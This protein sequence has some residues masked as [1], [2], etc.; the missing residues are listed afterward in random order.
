MKFS[1]LSL[2]AALTFGLIAPVAGAQTPYGHDL[3]E[4][5]T[6]KISAV[7][8]A[9][10][11]E[12]LIRKLK[13]VFPGMFDFLKES[14]FQMVSGHRYPSDDE[15]TVRYSL[16]FHKNVNGKYTYGDFSF[17]GEELRIES[18]HYQPLNIEDAFFPGKVSKDEAKEI[19]QS[20]LKKID[21]DTNYHFGGSEEYYYGNQTLTEPIQ[22]HF[23]FNREKNG[24][25]LIDQTTHITVYASGDVSSF[26]H[27]QQD[28]KKETFDKIDGLI[29][30]EEALKQVKDHLTLNLR[31]QIDYT[32]DYINPTLRLVYAPNEKV[33]GIHAQTGKWRTP[34]GLVDEYP[35]VSEYKQLVDE[36][37]K[38]RQEG[39]TIEDAKKFAEKFLAIDS[40]DVTLRIDSIDERTMFN[41][42]D[43]YSIHYSYDYYHGGIGTIMEIDKATGD[44]TSYYDMKKEILSPG[45]KGKV[46]LSSEDA[47]KKAISY[48]KQYAP[49]HLHNY[50]IPDADVEVD[51]WDNRY[52]FTF[53][54]IKDGLLVE[55][56]AL[57]VSVDAEN[58]NLLSLTNEFREFEKWPSLD[59]II[60]VEEAKAK[61]L[62]EIEIKLMYVPDNYG[63]E[64]HYDLLYVPS[65]ANGSY[66]Y[67]DAITGE[68]GGYFTE[69]KDTPTVSHPWAEDELNYLIQA[70]ILKID[71]IDAFNPDAKITK[72]E[73]LEITLRSL[74]S[75]YHYPYYDE[76]HRGTFENIPPD[77]PLF[78]I[79]ERAVML[80]ILD[81]NDKTF[82]LDE[83]LTRE[84]LAT[85]YIRALGLDTAGKQ[86]NIY[87]LS[88]K[89]KD[90]VSSEYRGYVALS[91]SLGLLTA[92]NDYFRPKQETT[93]AEIAVSSFRLAKE[94]QSRQNIWY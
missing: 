91:N 47:L 90:Q 72:G 27:Y 63:K 28:R 1:A 59:Q 41:G 51:S 81:R 73:A 60:S 20:L 62:D 78:E 9:V 68:W 19:A 86:H 94:M 21:P 46:V 23:T 26:Y 40:D 33:A 77:H 7:E 67:L 58:G 13:E 35:S 42:R 88:F 8:Q 22:Y 50:T 37:L 80:N 18:F 70:G 49:T 76:E 52:Y 69:K 61:F 48:L 30:K 32:M 71:D 56:D 29:E 55:G 36:P 89:D 10:T 44:I 79:V 38:P 54:R 5:P 34:S 92:S 16:N 83:T 93:F 17:L 2:T 74:M 14:D 84:E 12:E 31:Y 66:G 4:Q 25:P 64:V 11:K 87:Q 85:W 75:F 43:V 57:M 82:P 39:M 53:P 6:I 3:N 24:I 45:K 15:G 65:L